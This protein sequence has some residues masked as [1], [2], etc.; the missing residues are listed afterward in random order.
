MLEQSTVLCAGDAAELAKGA[1]GKLGRTVSSAMGITA[2][3][4]QETRYGRSRP[5]ERPASRP[6][7]FGGLGSGGLAPGSGLLGGMLGRIVASTL[8][9]AL[10]QMQAQQQQARLPAGARCTATSTKAAENTAE[11]HAV[12]ALSP[13][14]QTKRERALQTTPPCRTHKAR[15]TPTV[16]AKPSSMYAHLAMNPSV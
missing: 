2:P 6:P 13:A 1:L 5:A 12:L 9:G 11:S 8:G 15:G 14:S 16:L 10:E 4:P 7:F 3:P